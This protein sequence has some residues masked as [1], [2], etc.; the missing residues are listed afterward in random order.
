M[1]HSNARHRRD[2]LVCLQAHLILP[3][4]NS[5]IDTELIGSRIA[6]QIKIQPGVTKRSFSRIEERERERER[7]DEIK[8]NIS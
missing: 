8:E 5:V 2:P 7:E 1:S 6:C 3:S 4:M